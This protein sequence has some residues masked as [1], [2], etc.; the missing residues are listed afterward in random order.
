MKSAVVKF[1]LGLIAMPSDH[2]QIPAKRHRLQ[3]VD[4]YDV[5]SDEL[6][7]LQQVGSSVGTDLQFATFWLPIAIASLL[8]LIS[9][10][11]TDRHVFDVY[12]VATFVGFG[13]GFY[14]AFKWRSGTN[15]F[16]K[17]IDKIRERQV[18]PVG[19]QG[20]ELKPSELEQLP[21]GS[22]TEEPPANAE[23]LDTRENAK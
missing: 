4:L 13:F 16:K 8:T 23:P 11:I 7:K 2:D 14:F 17:C 15:E 22:P 21:A 19:E 12:L 20:K 18:G 3:H 10:P 6:D 1:L 9:V 5:S